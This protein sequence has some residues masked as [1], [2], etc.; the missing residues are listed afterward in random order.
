MFQG[1][2]NA[3]LKLL[4]AQGKGGILRTDDVVDIGYYVQKSVLDILKSK[5]PHAQPVSPA[6]LPHGSAVPPEVHP[7]VFDQITAACIR[8]A[9]IHTK[10][11]AGPFSLDAHCW[12]QLCTSFKSASHDL[13]H[14][15]AL[16]ARQLCSTLVDPKGISP[17]L[18][19]RLIALDKC[20]GVRPVGIC[21]SPGRIIAKAVL[22]VTKGDIQDATG[23]LQLCA[24]QIAGIEAAVHAV[25]SIFS[26]ADT[27]AAF[28]VDA[29]NAF[30]SL[31]RQVA[32][33]NARHLCLSLANI[34]INTYR[35]PSELF[36]V[37]LVLRSEEG[38][39]QG[40]PLAMPIN[41]CTGNHP[42]H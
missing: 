21:E 13:C 36:V 23:S 11:A 7:V 33:Y 29:S 28:L 19:C 12:R 40:D 8:R 4:S 5:H 18:A 38:T 17:F 27:E 37:G 39:T 20:P 25:R 22:F 1:K 26:M 3:A 41:V 2:I 42:P 14:A 34:L 16:L 9:A 35:E 24:G 32:L 30:N 10:G 31:N 15:L 6:A